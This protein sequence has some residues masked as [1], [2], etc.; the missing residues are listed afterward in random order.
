M[1]NIQSSSKTVIQ[2]YDLLDAAI[3]G[4]VD[5]FTD[6][7]YFGDPNQS[8]KQAQINQAEWLL[9]QIKCA[10]N[11]LFLFTLICC[12]EIVIPSAVAPLF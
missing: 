2:C 6:G 10:V 9:D 11:P 4:G 8:Y 3:S 7:K 12:F 1:D 5:D